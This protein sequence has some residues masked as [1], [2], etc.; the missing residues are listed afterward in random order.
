[1]LAEGLGPQRRIKSL[2]PTASGGRGQSHPAPFVPFVTFVA[3]SFVP[4]VLASGD[5]ASTSMS[6]AMS[7]WALYSFA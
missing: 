2:A 6:A 7:A 3:C 5:H 1:M 4:L